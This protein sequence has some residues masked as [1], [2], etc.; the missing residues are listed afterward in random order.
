MLCERIL[1]ASDTAGSAVDAEVPDFISFIVLDMPYLQTRLRGGLMW[2]DAFSK[3][4]HGNTFVRLSEAQQL[5]ILDQIAYPDK[6]NPSTEQGGRFFREIRNL[7]L[8]GYYTS[9]IGVNDLGFKGNAANVWDGVPADVL[10]DHE[11]DYEPEWLAKCVNQDRR[12]EIAEWDEE[13]NLLN[14]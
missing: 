5:G 7:I 3:K 8:T 6:L 10:A 12:I 11:V 2:L 13:G 14:N 1:P 9:E 4:Q